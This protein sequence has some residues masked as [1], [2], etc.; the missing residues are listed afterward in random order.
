MPFHTEL[1]RKYEVVED[2]TS[3]IESAERALKFVDATLDSSPDKNENLFLEFRG[4]MYQCTGRIYRKMSSLEQALLDFDI[5]S[6][7]FG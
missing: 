6:E 3:A 7:T 1:V 4:E 2:F 5:A